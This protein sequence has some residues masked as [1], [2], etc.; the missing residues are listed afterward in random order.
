MFIG[1]RNRKWYF[2]HQIIA[3]VPLLGSERALTK[4][5]WQRIPDYYKQYFRIETALNFFTLY[6]GNGFNYK[7]FQGLAQVIKEKNTAFATE[8]GSAGA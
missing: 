6:S 8:R 3:F 2:A 4:K 7:V 5:L 1:M